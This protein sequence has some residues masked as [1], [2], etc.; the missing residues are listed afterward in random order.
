LERDLTVFVALQHF[1]PSE[2]DAQA[3]DYLLDQLFEIFNERFGSGFDVEYV[4]IG[5]YAADIKQAPLEVAI[6]VCIG[7]RYPSDADV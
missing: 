6:V 2:Q 1:K 7:F 3:R 4:G 5:R